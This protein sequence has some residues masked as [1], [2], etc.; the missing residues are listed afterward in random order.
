MSNLDVDYYGDLKIHIE[1][2]GGLDSFLL[3]YTSPTAYPED[4][5]LQ[6]L[7]VKAESAMKSLNTYIKD[8]ITALGGNPEDYEY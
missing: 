6:N 8:K 4:P 5:E 7:M 3:Y 2:E 1:Q